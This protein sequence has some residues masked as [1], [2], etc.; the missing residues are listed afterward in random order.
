[1][2]KRSKSKATI[3]IADRVLQDA[4]RRKYKGELCEGCGEREFSCMHHHI[5]KS[6][7]NYL[8]FDKINLIFICSYCHPLISFGKG[9]QI[10]AR[11]SV[12]RGKAWI[13]KIGELAKIKRPSYGKKELEKI[14]TKF[15]KWKPKKEQS[16]AF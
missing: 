13:M 12:K 9:A 8:R 2:K 7:S 15:E 4:Y 11:Y 3:D 14:I 6:Q 5:N 10:I 1:M 16:T